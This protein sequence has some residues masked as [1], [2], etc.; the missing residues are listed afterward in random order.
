MPCSSQG[1]FTYLKLDC[2]NLSVMLRNLIQESYVKFCEST[3]AS[4]GS[5]ILI[6]LLKFQVCIDLKS[7]NAQLLKVF[8]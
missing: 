4:S 6:P 7:V 5:L 1:N 8:A 3:V 2:S